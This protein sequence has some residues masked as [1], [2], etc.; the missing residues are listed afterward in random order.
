MTETVTTVKLPLTSYAFKYCYQT[1][2]LGYM[3]LTGLL[4]SCQSV[5]PTLRVSPS[6]SQLSVC[7]TWTHSSLHQIA[8]IIQKRCYINVPL[9]NITLLKNITSNAQMSRNFK[10]LTRSEC[11]WTFCV[12]AVRIQDGKPSHWNRIP[13]GRTVTK[14]AAKTSRQRRQDSANQRPTSVAAQSG[15]KAFKAD[16][17]IEPVIG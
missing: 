14:R 11:F 3:A 5:S 10:A 6:S 7:H 17:Q 9:R 15:A 2:V 4:L 8:A 13:V 1:Q 16:N 12:A